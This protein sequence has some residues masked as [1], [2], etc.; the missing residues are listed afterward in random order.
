MNPTG[1]GARQNA[2]HLRFPGQAAALFA[3]VFVVYAAGAHLSWLSFGAGIGPAFFPAAGVTVAAMVLTRRSLW[4][5]VAAAVVVAEFGVDLFYGETPL[6]AVGY[7]VANAVEPLVG[8]STVLA[9]GGGR[10]DL[11]ERR[12]LGVFLAGA[13]VLGPVVGGIIGGFVTSRDGGPSWLSDA[14]H[15]AIGDGIGVLVV[16]P[17]ILLWVRQ[18]YVLR[19][20]PVESAIV[21]LATAVTSLVAFSIE[22][23]PAMVVL[24]VLAWAA[25]RLNMIGAALSGLIM[26]FFGN[27]LTRMGRGVFVG[28]D[29]PPATRLALTQL[30]IAM[31]VVVALL[32]AQEV[33]GRTAAVQARESERRERLRLQGLAGL[34]QQLSAA[35]TA[36]DIGGALVDQVLNEA[37]A[38]SVNLG[39]VSDD[40]STLEWAAMAGYPDEVF[41]EYAGGVPLWENTL[42][43]E[44]IRT[45]RPVLVHTASEYAHRYPDKVRWLQISGAQS[46]VGWPLTGGGRPIGALLLVWSQPEPL[47][48]AQLA[49]VST[50]ATMVAQALVRSRVYADEH[51]RAAVLQSAVLPTAP[52]KT[53][54]FDVC[55][56]YEPADV[57]QGLGGDWYDVM[58]LPKGRTYLAVGDVVGHGLRA[59]EDMAQL[60]SAGRALAHQG[61]P[62]GQ[63]LAE[64]NGFTRHAS[65][66]RFATMAVAVFDNTA[67]TL[68][69]ACAGH[70]PPL[71]RRVETGAVLRLDD[72]H[73]PVLGPLPAAAYGEGTTRIQPGDTLMMYTDGLVERRGM[74][75]DDG[76]DRAVRMFADWTADRDL[77]GASLNLREALA[78][79]PRA[80][81]V[82]MIAV[83]FTDPVPDDGSAV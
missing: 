8:A 60:R 76:I 78:P 21:L 3:V 72:G 47:D 71:L 34:A 36:R 54:G 79:R 19:A 7:A 9:L 24:P 68:T 59:V 42:A 5:A 31:V 22:L 33:A 38:R 65:Q 17:P 15:W 74:G 81:D 51:A 16:A 48:T 73:G 28:A 18:S 52:A 37:G 64:L 13:T 25:F 45:G 53:S 63:L 35:L 61:L 82:C 2:A 29:F 12:D 57:A 55:I 27:V 49:Y 43:T 32:I 6:R 75:L 50:V 70:P 77:E 58:P 23:P 39:L 11:R 66:G 44:V 26:A 80:D 69:Y 30:F 83:R 40:R 46:V 14:L 67:G 62:P 4:P 10:P 41:E 56:T 1:G 20:R